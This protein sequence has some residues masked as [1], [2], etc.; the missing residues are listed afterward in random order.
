MKKTYL[1]IAYL[2]LLS[3]ARYYNKIDLFEGILLIVI[4]LKIMKTIHD[5]VDDIFK[6]NDYDPWNT[7]Y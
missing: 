6:D 1:L 2:V 7:K 4:F 5:N 3:V